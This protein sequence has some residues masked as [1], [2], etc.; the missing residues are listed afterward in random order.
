MPS[1]EEIF[2]GGFAEQYGLQA[3]F[4][5]LAGG[6]FGEGFGWGGAVGVLEALALAEGVVGEDDEAGAGE[7]GG[8]GVIARFAKGRV[9]GSHDDRGEST[10]WQGV[11]LVEKRGD[12]EAGL[13]I[14]QSAADGD[15]GGFGFA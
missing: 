10:R 13:G 5:V 8:K 7:S 15:A 2:G 12:V 11:R 9:A 6:A 1:P 4:G 14:E 3:G